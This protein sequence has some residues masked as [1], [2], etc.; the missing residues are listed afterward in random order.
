MRLKKSRAVNLVILV[1]LLSGFSPPHLSNS[2]KRQRIV[3][4]GQSC[5][6]HWTC[7]RRFPGVVWLARKYVKPSSYGD[8]IVNVLA[9]DPALIALRA[10]RT[11]YDNK[12]ESVLSMG[13]RTEALAGV[14]GGFFCHEQNDICASNASTSPPNCPPSVQPLS[15][16][17]MSGVT[18]SFNC[19]SRTSLGIT[20]EELPKIQQIGCGQDWP[21]VTYAIGAGPNL[22]T[23]GRKNITKEGFVWYTEQAPRTAVAMTSDGNLLLVTI[24]GRT[25]GAD[26]M[27]IDM[28][29]D[30]LI[31]EFRVVSAMN[32]DG[33][34]ST[35]M[36][37]GGKIV[38]KPSD[39]SCD[40]CCR[41]VYDGL[42]VYAK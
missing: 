4:A 31:S 20:K 42:F 1:L 21:S 19:A 15:L 23:S 14:N 7:E 11:K 41:C 27:T 12:Y 6:E 2:Y 10:V 39:Q 18:Y 8:Q 33:G 28:L 3:S 26:G 29:A 37:L 32:L 30:F 24:D 40:G 22:V 38:N 17:I 25:A 35:T 13:R 36:Y 9:V 34:G 16:L 5:P